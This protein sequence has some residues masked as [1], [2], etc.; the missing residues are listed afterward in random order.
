MNP[1]C[2]T[3]APA[4]A[5]SRTAAVSHMRSI[6][7]TPAITTSSAGAMYR[8]SLFFGA[9]SDVPI[10]IVATARHTSGHPRSGMRPLAAAAV[11]STLQNRVEHRLPAELA[12]RLV[13]A[14]GALAVLFSIALAAQTLYRYL[15]GDALGGFTTV[16]LLQLM[17]SGLL[18]GSVGAWS[19]ST[20]PSST[21]KPRAAR[22]IWYAS[23]GS[24]RRL[25]DP[26]PKR[27]SFPR[28]RSRSHGRA[29]PYRATRRHSSTYDPTPTSTHFLYASLA[30][31]LSPSA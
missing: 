6:A 24:E 30:P 12:L 9:A 2:T 31:A 3:S 15:A 4:V 16:I 10:M 22:S 21:P 17:L 28:P 11:Q 25:R 29:Q 27:T 1:R 20:S 26:Q 23:R 5:S 14:S 13:A 19:P 8:R 7:L 18:L